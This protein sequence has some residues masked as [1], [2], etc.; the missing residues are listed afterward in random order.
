MCISEVNQSV[1][2]EAIFWTIYYN[3]F[4]SGFFKFLRTIYRAL[5]LW[6]LSKKR[7]GV[8]YFNAQDD[9][10][11]L[12]ISAAAMMILWTFQEQSRHVLTVI[13]G[14]WVLRLAI[15]FRIS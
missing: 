13:S 6:N 4:E 1:L 15:L 8:F 7:S 14:K 10:I 9:I 2:V 12:S 3:F 5:P 11:L